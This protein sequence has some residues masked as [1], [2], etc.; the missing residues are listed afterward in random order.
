MLEEYYVLMTCIPIEKQCFIEFI[1]AVFMLLPES[2]MMP[3]V[4]PFMYICI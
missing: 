1:K 3:P 2:T 4:R